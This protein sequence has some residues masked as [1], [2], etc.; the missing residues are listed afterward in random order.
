MIKLSNLYNPFSFLVSEQACCILIEKREDNKLVS[1]L[2]F[3]KNTKSYYGMKL[4][5]YS[6]HDRWEHTI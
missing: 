5:Y 2:T 4:I 1:F 3:K 6:Q